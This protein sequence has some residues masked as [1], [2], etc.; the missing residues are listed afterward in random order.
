VLTGEQTALSSHGAVKSEWRTMPR[1]KRTS[2][3]QSS[4]VTV[5]MRKSAH[6]NGQ[7]STNGALGSDVI[8]C[9]GNGAIQSW[10][11]AMNRGMIWKT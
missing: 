8:D 10:H 2:I 4:A 7:R 5:A 1:Q 11:W 6:L 9:I 3:G